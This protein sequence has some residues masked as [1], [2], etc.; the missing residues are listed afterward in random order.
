MAIII[1]AIGIEI[2]DEV[3]T[4]VTLRKPD[5]PT[6]LP[7]DNGPTILNPGLSLYEVQTL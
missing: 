3:T 1:M 7:D 6:R 4:V 5:K 2:V